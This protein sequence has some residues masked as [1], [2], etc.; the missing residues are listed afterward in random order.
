[1]DP[2][3]REKFPEVV[4][5]G[6]GGELFKDSF[7]ICVGV[8]SENTAILNHGVEHSTPPAS[9][10]PSDEEPV[11][12]SYLGGAHS[13]LNRVVV[14]VN[15][16]AVDV[17]DEFAPLVQCIGRRSTQPAFGE[18]FALNFGDEVVKAFGDRASLS[19]SIV[20]AHFGG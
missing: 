6:R 17:D 1:M 11:F 19:S 13:A 8:F 14:D 10:F 9:V 4:L 20:F 3:R 2:R 7:Q 18:V 5:V 12:E 15:F 16:S